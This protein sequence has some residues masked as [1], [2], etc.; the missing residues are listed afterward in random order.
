MKFTTI[1]LLKDTNILQD[2]QKLKAIIE[3]KFVLLKNVTEHF[4][5]FGPLHT[6]NFHAM[7]VEKFCVDR[8]LDSSWRKR[9]DIFEIHDSSTKINGGGWFQFDFSKKTLIAIGSSTAYGRFDES[10]FEEFIA[11]DSVFED[12]SLKIG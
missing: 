2:S 3:C 11:T 5:I 4:L 7:L 12:F 6:Y 8:K 10:V 1:D 9:P